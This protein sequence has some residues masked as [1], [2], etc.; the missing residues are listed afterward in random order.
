MSYAV[1]MAYVDANGVPEER[2]RL[3]ASLAEKF[4]ATLIG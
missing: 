4:R 3:A 2:V 1:A